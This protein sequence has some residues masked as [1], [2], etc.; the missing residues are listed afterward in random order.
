MIGSDAYE[1]LTKAVLR[2]SS[3]VLVE[4]LDRETF[5]RIEWSTRG[6]IENVLNSQIE[7][8]LTE[9]LSEKRVALKRS[10]R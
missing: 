10:Q 6:E 1:T 9:V 3:S 2:A 4:T 7:R 8:S 5:T